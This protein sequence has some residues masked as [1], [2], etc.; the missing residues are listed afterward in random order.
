[1]KKKLELIQDLNSIIESTD[2]E[3]SEV[4]MAKLVS[5]R[6]HLVR[7]KKIDDVITWSAELLRIAEF[8]QMFLKK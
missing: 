7:S 6:A 5:I 3:F 8:V 1:M 4:E 2:H